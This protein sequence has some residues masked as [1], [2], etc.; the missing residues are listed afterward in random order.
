MWTS[1]GGAGG[2]YRGDTEPPRP[3]EERVVCVCR[4]MAL[5]VWP[6]LSTEIPNARWKTVDL[7]ETKKLPLAHQSQRANASLTS[8]KSQPVTT[9]HEKNVKRRATW[10]A[11]TGH[12]QYALAELSL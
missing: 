2:G 5:R 1:S 4:S 7:K 9:W 10:T 6:F 12:Q 3:V 11:R 8:P